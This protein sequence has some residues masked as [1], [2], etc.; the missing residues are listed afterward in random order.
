MASVFALI[1]ILLA[2]GALLKKSLKTCQQFISI[3]WGE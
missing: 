2:L 1:E 3:L